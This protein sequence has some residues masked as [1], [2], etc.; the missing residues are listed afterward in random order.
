MDLAAI[1]VGLDGLIAGSN[2]KALCF[3]LEPSSLKPLVGHLMVHIFKSPLL[4]LGIAR[5]LVYLPIFVSINLRHGALLSVYLFCHDIWS[6][7]RRFQCFIKVNSLLNIVAWLD[8]E[9]Q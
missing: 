9:Y 5:A 7:I 8:T 1:V 2:D 6:F 3:G 4:F